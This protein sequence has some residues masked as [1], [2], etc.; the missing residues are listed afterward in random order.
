MV[1][2]VGKWGGVGRP[3]RRQHAWQP[4]LMAAMAPWGRPHKQSVLGGETPPKQ[5]ASLWRRG[6]EG[7]VCMCVW[8]PP[9]LIAFACVGG[10]APN[11]PRGGIV[12]GS[13]SSSCQALPH[14]PTILFTS[15]TR[16]TTTQPDSLSQLRETIC[17]SCASFNLLSSAGA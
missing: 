5:A 4:Q 6:G 12:V 15:H 9:C 16:R 2:G 11:R 7:G 8:P 17:P 10:V 14:S 1:C 3:C 13:S